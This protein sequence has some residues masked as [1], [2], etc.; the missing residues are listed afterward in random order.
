MSTDQAEIT[1]FEPAHV[2]PP[3]E[4]EPDPG[5]TCEGC[6]SHVSPQFGRVLGDNDGVVHR[7]PRCASSKELF[8][9]AGAD[10]GGDL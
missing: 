10:V 6:D 1:E 4:P 3:S 7:C 2:R 9:G 5:R 8:R